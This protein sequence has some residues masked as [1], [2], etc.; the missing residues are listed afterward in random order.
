MS[1]EPSSPADRTESAP[2]RKLTASLET[3]HRP[4]RRRFLHTAALAAGT[5]ELLVGPTAQAADSDSA[6]KPASGPRTNGQPWGSDHWEAGDLVHL[7]PLVNHERMRIKL[8]LRK[9]RRTAPRLRV[10]RRRVEGRMSDTT[11]RYWVFDVGGLR[12]DRRYELQLFEN[13]GRPICDA[14]PLKTFPAPDAL[15][16][17]VRL[18]IYTCAGGNEDARLPIGGSFFLNIAARQRLLERGLS[19]APDAV[20]GVGDQVYWDLESGLNHPR[21]GKFVRRFYDRFGRFDFDQPVLGSENETVLTRVVDPQLA[22]LYGVRLRSVPTFLTQDDHDYFE[23][24]VAS[25]RLVT[26]PPAP[27]MQRLAKATQRLYFPE[28]LPDA[29]LPLGLPGVVGSDRRRA[30]SQSFAAL[31]YGRLLELLMYDCRRCMT[32]KGPTAG[33]L[34]RGVERWLIKRTQ[35]EDDALHLVHVPSTPLGWSAGKWGEWY[36]DVLQSDGTL[37]TAVEKPYWQ[38]G[39][40]AQHQ[41]LIEAVAAQEKRIPL[42][43]SGDLHAVGAGH[44]QRS[45]RLQLPRGVTSLLTGPIGTAGPLWPSAFRGTAPQPSTRLT[46]EAVLTP[47]EKNGFT[48]LDITPQAIAVRQFAWRPPQPVDTIGELA[49]VCQFTLHRKA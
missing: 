46:L 34:S 37:S 20:I 26:F 41:R 16:D 40:W 2:G 42:V 3:L 5:A 49:P 17:R 32:L 10:D 24:D 47:I 36:P 9:P 1:D 6:D 8:S 31:R 4:T 29:R 11:G 19:F 44:I 39:W 13:D 38:P 14:W 45:G 30:I 12:P 7:L 21:I 15:P 25:D 28:L 27:Y 23:N 43:A 18:L 35:A 33:F 48:L 22:Q